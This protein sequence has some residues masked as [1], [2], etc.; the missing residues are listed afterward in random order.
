MQTCSNLI[1]CV[2]KSHILSQVGLLLVISF[3]QFSLLTAFAAHK[4]LLPVQA[5]I[6]TND[7]NL[8]GM[9]TYP[10]SDSHTSLKPRKHV[11]ME[12]QTKC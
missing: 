9:S 3:S 6:Q 4:T 10:F 11:T 7:W 2:G 1:L 8:W 5:E 12:T